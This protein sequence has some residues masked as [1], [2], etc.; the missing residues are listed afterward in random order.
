MSP[1]VWRGL[2]S[3]GEELVVSVGV[4]RDADR[5]L[6]HMQAIV[7]ETD[8]LLQSAEDELPD[9]TTQR[10]ILDQFGRLENCL[11]LIAHRPGLIRQELLGSITL[12]GGMTRRSRHIAKLGMGVRRY[13]WRRGIGRALVVQSLKWATQNE[14]VERVTLQVYSS[15]TAA[16][17]LYES[18]GFETD[19]NLRDE[20]QLEDRLEDLVTMSRST[21]REH[22]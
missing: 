4:R 10:A 20:V 22:S 1:V 19:G 14:L 18:M 3:R 8:L 15:N 11:C 12:L 2:D 6:S 21:H 7:N 16:M 5:F 13:A 9:P 17:S